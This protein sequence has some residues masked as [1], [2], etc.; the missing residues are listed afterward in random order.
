MV[1]NKKKNF[2]GKENTEN[3]RQIKYKEILYSKSFN[4]K[5]LKCLLLIIFF[6][7]ISLTKERSLNIRILNN[8]SIITMIINGG[9]T[10]RIIGEY[11]AFPSSGDEVYINNKKQDNSPKREYE[12]DYGPNNVTIK[13]QNQINSCLNMFYNMLDLLEV[14]LSKFDSSQI[15]NTKEMF[16]GCKNLKKID[17]GSFNTSKVIEMYSMFKGC[18]SLVSLEL[19]FDFS[20][21]NTIC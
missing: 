5:F 15:T 11:F 9:G 13:F 3:K 12:L 6:N 2:D 8:Y 20:S 16:C 14:D 7:S 17:F 10:K 18:T 21:A 19:N 4:Q 1:K